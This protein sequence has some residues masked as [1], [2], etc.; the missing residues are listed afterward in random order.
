MFEKVFYLSIFYCL[1]FIN[2]ISENKVEE[3]LMEDIDS[4]LKR[5]GYF[6]VYHDRDDHWKED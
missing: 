4:D 5:E 3:K 6:R 1:C 2:D